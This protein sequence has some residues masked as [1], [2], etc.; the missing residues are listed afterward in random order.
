[1][2]DPQI[3]IEFILFLKFW[4]IQ[5]VENIND[6]AAPSHTNSFLIQ[7]RKPLFGIAI[8]P[9]VMLGGAL[10]LKHSAG[11]LKILWPGK[12]QPM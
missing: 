8:K 11:G 9:P 4:L 7:A 5:M 10:C 3:H 12:P 1:V 6:T 2:Q